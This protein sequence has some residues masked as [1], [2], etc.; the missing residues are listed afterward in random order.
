[1]IKLSLSL[2]ASLLLPFTEKASESIFE[3]SQ[4]LFYAIFME[5]AIFRNQAR[6]EGA[7]NKNPSLP[8]TKKSL[9]VIM[10]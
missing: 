4:S 7:K 1:M 6:K 10:E 5:T 2:S 9:Q 8:A 3:E